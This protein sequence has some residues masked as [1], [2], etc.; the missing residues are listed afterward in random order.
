MQGAAHGAQCCPRRESRPDFLL[1]AGLEGGFAGDAAPVLAGQPVLAIAGAL[2]TAAAPVLGGEAA[3]SS[4]GAV[5]AGSGA[6]AAAAGSGAGAAS[7]GSGAGG[8]DGG[9]H[10][11]RTDEPVAAPEHPEGAGRHI[12]TIIA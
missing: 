6:G 2:A 9:A 10:V 11:R 7:A 4:S 12:R 1:F 5:A 8:T 3:G